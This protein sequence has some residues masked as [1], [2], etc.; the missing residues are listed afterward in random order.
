MKVTIYTYRCVNGSCR[1]IEKTS[2]VKKTQ[3]TCPKCGKHMRLI[4]TEKE[5]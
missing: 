2:G 1:S 4:S 5:G 3:I